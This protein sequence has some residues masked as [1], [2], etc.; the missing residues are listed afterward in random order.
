MTSGSCPRC[1]EPLIQIATPGGS[2]YRCP[3]CTGHAFTASAAKKVTTAHAVTA[4]L[5][6]AASN[7]GNQ[8]AACPWCSLPMREVSIPSKVGTT[9]VDVCT[10]CQLFWLDRDEAKQLPSINSEFVQTPRIAQHTCRQCGAPA[11]PDLDAYCKYCGHAMAPARTPGVTESTMEPRHRSPGV[12]ADADAGRSDSTK[13]VD[14]LAW[15]VRALL[16]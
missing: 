13:L 4:L 7:D 14:G 2:L 12:D 10:S 3:T 9:T 11:R 5:V 1:G 8:G 6:A 16:D 15:I